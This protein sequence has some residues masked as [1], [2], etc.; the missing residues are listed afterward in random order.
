MRAE[1][2]AENRRGDAVPEGGALEQEGCVGAGL[3]WGRTVLQ[4]RVAVTGVCLTAEAALGA[5]L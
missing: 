3:Q 4:S 2:E 5:E 1:R